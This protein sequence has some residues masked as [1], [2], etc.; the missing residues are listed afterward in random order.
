VTLARQIDGV[1][2]NR[3]LTGKGTA[4]LLDARLRVSGRLERWL[5]AYGLTPAAR[6]SWAAALAR[7]G[8]VAEEIARRRE[9]AS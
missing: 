2:A 4:S 8:S 7:G 5:A 1:L 3:T 9:A 6:A